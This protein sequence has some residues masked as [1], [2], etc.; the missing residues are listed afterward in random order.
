MT[1]HAATPV[2]ARWLAALGFLV[3]WGSLITAIVLTG[4]R[5][6]LLL[7]TVSLIVIALAAY[8]WVLY[9]LAG[10]AAISV[11][12]LVAVSWAGGVAGDRL[13]GW[14]VAVLAVLV[15]VAAFQRRRWGRRFQRLEQGG[16]D[17]DEERV[18]KKPA[19][20]AATQARETMRKKH[21]R[22]AQL[23][24]V[25]ERLSSLTDLEAIGQLAVE[26]ALARSE[27]RRVGK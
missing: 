7:H 20:A 21:G 11:L 13:L 17:L 15:G 14:D 8:A 27:E 12:A 9:P 6:A 25:A 18:L 16:D 19:L 10:S 4:E 22:Y 5:D 3:V 26:R 23:Q 2:T 1:V 24:A